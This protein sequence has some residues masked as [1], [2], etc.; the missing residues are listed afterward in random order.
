MKVAKMVKETFVCFL[1]F[2]GTAD[3]N[4]NERPIL[5]L[6]FFFHYV[7]LPQTNEIFHRDQFNAS[8]CISCVYRFRNDYYRIIFRFYRRQKV[9]QKIS[10]Y[11]VQT[12]H[13]HTRANIRLCLFRTP[14]IMDFVHRS[15]GNRNVNSH[16]DLLKRKAYPTDGRRW[17]SDAQKEITQ[18]CLQW[19]K[20]LHL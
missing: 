11:V 6:D 17:S 1:L 7:S 16:F 8:L 10:I 3:S 4:D 18:Q 13:A 5:V 12:T 20:R 19:I 14:W 15:N 2:I 9:Q